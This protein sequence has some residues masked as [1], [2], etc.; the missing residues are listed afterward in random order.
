M[1]RSQ[2][3]SLQERIDAKQIVPNQSIKLSENANL[4][5]DYE[6][7]STTY[8]EYIRGVDIS[9][10]I[11]FKGRNRSKKNSRKNISEAK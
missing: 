5:N 10:D 6:K 9:A 4:L 2:N 8:Q 11:E 1:N 3:H 7:L